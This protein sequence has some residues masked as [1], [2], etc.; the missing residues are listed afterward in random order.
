M[1]CIILDFAKSKGLN[2]LCYILDDRLGLGSLLSYA[3][4]LRK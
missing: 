4:H 3:I 1:L 2:L